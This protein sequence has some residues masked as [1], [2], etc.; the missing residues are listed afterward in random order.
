MTLN[1]NTIEFGGRKAVLNSYS[2]HPELFAGMNRQREQ[3]AARYPNATVKTER[4]CESEC[5]RLVADAKA[6][7][8]LRYLEQEIGEASNAAAVQS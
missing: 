8:H 4:M 1:V 5:R 3:W 6:L 7:G 2:D